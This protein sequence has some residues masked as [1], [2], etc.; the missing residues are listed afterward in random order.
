[1]KAVILLAGLGTR[2]R[3]H[4]Y[5]RPKPL[6]N[7][8]GKP[9]LAHILDG[10]AELQ[11]D[12]IIFIVGY[13]G[14]QIE[15]FVADNYRRLN[16]RFVFQ[17]EMRGQAHAI[18]LARDYIN[19][20]VLIIFGD[21]I[22]E[23]DWTRLQRVKSDGLIYCHQVS[24]PRRFGVVTLDNGF[25]T[26]F[27]EKPQTPVSNL[28]VVGVYYFRA[29]QKLMQAID[30]IIVNNI[31]TKGEFYLADAMQRMIEQGARL[32]AEPISVW[33]DCGTREALLHTNRYLLAK[34][35]VAVG[36]SEASHIIPPVH[37]ARGA[38]VRRSIVGPNVS[39]SEGAVIEDSIL[40]DCIIS[41]EAQ[42][43]NAMLEW[44]LVG[45]NARVH[46]AFER[47]NVGDSSEIDF[48]E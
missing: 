24:D 22:W 25:V 19:Q 39:I 45:S 44:S 20:D 32:E 33:E 10:M 9:V 13:L 41:Q 29:W 48:A 6:V 4:T 7:V 11:F 18:N 26:R 12:E 34:N 38:L 40:R 28:A 47:L 37:I 46:G 1:M 21:T 27:V 15:K 30:D 17:E 3:P 42:V 14:E 5:S 8:A 36:E 31:Q 35:G 23:T 16:S 43:S 2:L